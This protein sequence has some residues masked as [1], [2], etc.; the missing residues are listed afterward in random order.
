MKWEGQAAGT[1]AGDSTCRWGRDAA[2][3]GT[4]QDRLTPNTQGRGRKARVKQTEAVRVSLRTSGRACPGEVPCSGVVTTGS[5]Y[6]RCL[7][8]RNGHHPCRSP[9]RACTSD[10]LARL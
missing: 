7:R 5:C 4:V 1:R 10:S 3:Q 8:Q 6:L 9:P 2:Q